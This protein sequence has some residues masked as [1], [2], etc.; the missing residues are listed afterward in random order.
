MT[1]NAVVREI[2]ALEKRC[3]PGERAKFARMLARDLKT[4]ERK[5]ARREQWND[6]EDGDAAKTADDL[7]ESADRAKQSAQRAASRTYSRARKAGRAAAKA[8]RLT[9][10][11]TRAAAKFT[12]RVARAAAEKIAQRFAQSGS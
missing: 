2:D 3:N 4:V 10:R 1:L 9:A 11:A 6:S 7:E 8:A 12:A 5:I